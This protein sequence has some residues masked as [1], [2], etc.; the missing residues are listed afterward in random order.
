L[1]RKASGFKS[2]LPHHAWVKETDMKIISLEQCPKAKTNMEGAE[3]VYKQVPISKTDGTPV[4]SFR[5]F[6]IEPGGHIPL[7]M[8]I[9]SST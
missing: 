2:P 3:G 4:F 5:V 1:C 9:R 6:T 7:F 8:L